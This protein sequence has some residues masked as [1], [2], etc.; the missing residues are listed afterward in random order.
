M[1]PGAPL[2]TPGRSYATDALLRLIA[3]VAEPHAIM[4]MR[5]VG[6]NSIDPAGTG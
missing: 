1:A 6:P 3:N 4:P 2:Q 5:A